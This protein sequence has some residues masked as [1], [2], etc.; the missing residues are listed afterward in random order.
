MVDLVSLFVLIQAALRPSCA[1]SECQQYVYCISVHT[2][3]S[4]T[5]I[6][7]LQFLVTDF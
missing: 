7:E 1:C 6:G 4:C 2:A 3:I 5:E